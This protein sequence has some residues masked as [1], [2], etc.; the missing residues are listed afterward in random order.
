MKKTL[1]ILILTVAVAIG[2]S[3]SKSTSQLR[4]AKDISFEYSAITRGSSVNYLVTKD[5]ITQKENSRGEIT[6]YKKP[7]DDKDW[8]DL[9]NA[10]EKVD[11]EK[12]GTIE[13]PSKKHQF[14]GAM[15]ATLKIT[16]NGKTYQTQTF[17]HGNPPAAI[18]DIID[19]ITVI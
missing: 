12:L 11:L 16:V 5:S 14:D 3:T 6:T 10:T 1:S 17:D 15:G 9:L 7:V 2:C 18:K 8:D 19:N 13:A 4:Q